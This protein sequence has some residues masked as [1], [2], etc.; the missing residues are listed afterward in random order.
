MKPGSL[1]IS[2]DDVEYLH[3]WSD[4]EIRVPFLD[5]FFNMATIQEETTM[6]KSREGHICQLSWACVDVLTCIMM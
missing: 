5:H 4:N 1:N 3:F 2:G 6:K